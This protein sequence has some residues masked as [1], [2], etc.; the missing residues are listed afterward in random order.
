MGG[1]LGDND[2]VFGGLHFFLFFILSSCSICTLCGEKLCDAIVI[3]QRNG[4][5]KGKNWGK[6]MPKKG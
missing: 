2:L 6:N 5:C 1:G 3:C 4:F